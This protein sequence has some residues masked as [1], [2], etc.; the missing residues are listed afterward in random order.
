MARKET[1]RSATPAGTRRAAEEEL[2]ELKAQLRILTDEAAKNEVILRKTQERELDLL[3]A[4]SL[5]ALL[6][7]L[8][9]G[10]GDSYALDAVTLVL[11][12]PQHEIRHLLIGGGQRLEDFP[13]VMFVESLAGMAPPFANLQ[14][15]WLGPYVGS[16]HQ[17]VFPGGRPLKSVALIPLPRQ[18]RLTGTLNFGSLDPKR[19]T[20]HHATDF[21]AHL[22]IIAAVCLENAVNRA[23]L[24]RSGMTDFLTGW[25]NRRYLHTRIKE[26][27]ARAQRHG[28]PVAC[29]MIDLDH[30]KQINDAFGHLAGDHVLRELAQR[31]DGQIRGSDTAARFGGDEF[32]ILLPETSAAEAAQL[33]ERIRQ[34]VCCNPVDVGTGHTH[35]LSISIGV[36]AVNPGRGERDLKAV[37]DGLLAEAD[38]ALYRAKARGRGRVEAAAQAGGAA[39]PMNR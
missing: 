28:T 26:E 20:R 19:F 2:R 10:L 32:A 15:P 7:V 23:R 3:K 34:I 25:H 36:A 11:L 18:D 6:G 30:F 17:L 13:G 27:L 22:G 9:H 38:A 1:V 31:I 8:V 33:A 21:L 24:L 4:E 39:H 14:R 35:P 12:D 5:A 16:D 37:A 29:L